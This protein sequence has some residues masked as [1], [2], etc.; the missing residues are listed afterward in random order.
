MV[1][2]LVRQLDLRLRVLLPFQLVHLR[3]F[4]SNQNEQSQSV[5]KPEGKHKA[6]TLLQLAFR[7]LEILSKIVQL[8]LARPREFLHKVLLPLRLEFLVVINLRVAAL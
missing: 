3:D 5:T 2:R 8:L 4:C 1:L 6:S 7:Q